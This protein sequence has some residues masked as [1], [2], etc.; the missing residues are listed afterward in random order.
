MLS[1]TS[2]SPSL[3]ISQVHSSVP[4]EHLLR[5]L[6]LLSES[7]DNKSAALKILV[8]SNFERFVRAKATID[9]VYKEMRDHGTEPGSPSKS[10]HTSRPSNSLR[11][12]SNS[13]LPGDKRAPNDK[14]K[15]ALLKESEY[16]TLGIKAALKDATAKA[17]E[18]WGP[19]LGGREREEALKSVMAS[20][21]QNRHIFEAGAALEDAIKRRDYEALAEQYTNVQTLAKDA[22]TVADRARDNRVEL[23]DAQ[24]YQIVLTG[25][26]WMDAKER[27]EEFKRNTWKKLAN[28][29][30]STKSMA[31]D[32]KQ[33]EFME[34]I[35]ILLQLGVDDNPVVIWLYSRYD[36]LRNKI[37]RRS[38]RIRLELEV[39]RRKLASVNRPSSKTLASY[40]RIAADKKQKSLENEMDSSS[41][42]QFWGR[43]VSALNSLLSTKGG[44]LGEITEYWETTLSFIEGMRQRSL[45]IGID[46]S[47]RK[48]HRLS[49]EIV[50]DLQEGAADLFSLLREKV[51]GLFVEPPLDDVTS[52]FSPP[53]QTPKTP[54]SASLLSPRTPTVFS[55]DPK[56]IPPLA[57]PTPASEQFDKFAFWPPQS[58][59]LSGSTYL[60]KANNIIASAAAELAS[61]DLIKQDSRLLQQFR[62]LVGD[63]RE[64]SISAV[65]IAWVADSENCR[66]LEDWTR[67]P[68]SPDLTNM[69]ARFNAFETALL[70]NL[71]RIMYVPDAAAANGSGS[72]DVVTQP[73]RGQNEV[74]QRGFRNSMYKAFNEMM[75]HAKRPAAERGGDIDEMVDLTIPATRDIGGKSTGG[76]GVT[77]E[78]IDVSSS[79]SSPHASAFTIFGESAFH[80]SLRFYV[81]F[82]E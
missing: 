80:R 21:E 72:G 55:F 54:H 61:V 47:S 68:D 70:T 23:S 64:R 73:T 59:S 50:K 65:C 18:V 36:Y 77:R 26:I 17:E 46:G 81:V 39:Q 78:S 71:Q 7:I 69:P 57:P 41:V 49:R 5:G 11:S 44:L 74:V 20:I 2:F 35:S 67:S 40:L 27:I 75:E 14:K 43:E 15:N 30:V 45:P 76:G 24:V 10:R 3:F 62:T 9:N 33:E 32:N 34:M 42:V 53:A 1:S 22:K 56:D 29:H 16:G 28:A 82:D 37:S 12:A 31:P 25:R 13:L 58:N 66:E 38:D 60:S 8:E 6:D 48:H 79:V 19:A 4:T 51:H 52:L 63:V